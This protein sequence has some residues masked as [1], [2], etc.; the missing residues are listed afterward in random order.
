MSKPETLIHLVSEQTLQNLLP[1]LALRPQRVV[2]VRSGNPEIAA[3][4]GYLHDAVA[5]LRANPLYRGFAP[6]F[7]DVVLPSASPGIEETREHV[8]AVLGRCRDA[9]VN[10]TGGTKLMSVGA[11]EAARSSGAGTLYCDTQE[12]RFLVTDPARF[13]RLPAFELL[14]ALLTVPVLLAAHGAARDQWRT[15]PCPERFLDF[16][17]RAWA[18]RDANRDLPELRAYDDAVRLHFRCEGKGRVPD[19]KQKLRELAAKPLPRPTNAVVTRLLDIARDAGLLRRDNAGN[20][21]VTCAAERAGVEQLDNL[22]RA[23]WL[24]LFVVDLLKRNPAFTDVC[25][26]LAPVRSQQVAFGET[27]VLCVDVRHCA[28]LMVSCKTSLPEAK[29]EHIEAVAQRARDFGGSHARAALALFGARDDLAAT[30]RHWGRIL[31][32]EVWIGAQIPKA[33]DPGQPSQ[34][35]DATP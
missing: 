27:D 5:E 4:S 2:Q 25:W 23:T 12:N 13:P 9:V 10:F 18:I 34:R 22:L 33:M 32:V 20:V 6:E 35:Q 8:S 14:A 17:R 29:L 21:F 30:L 7:E 24:E 11:Y 19:S 31:K 16:A 15:Q 28:L 26:S 3:R 1:I